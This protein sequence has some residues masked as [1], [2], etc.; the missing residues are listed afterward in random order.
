MRGFQ[1]PKYELVCGGCWMYA[2]RIGGLSVVT[3][4]LLQRVEDQV[5]LC[6]FDSFI[7]LGIGIFAAIGRLQDPFGANRQVR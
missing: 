3:V 4:C 6:L 1:N 2:Q 7:V 5:S